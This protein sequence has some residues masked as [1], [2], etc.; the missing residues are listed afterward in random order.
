M[1]DKAGGDGG[2]MAQSSTLKDNGI[3]HGTRPPMMSLKDSLTLL[4]A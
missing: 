1:T 4:S 2:G 3:N